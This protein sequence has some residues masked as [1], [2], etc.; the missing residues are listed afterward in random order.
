MGNQDS[1]L[2]STE[3]LGKKLFVAARDADTKTVRKII[4]FGLS[5]RTPYEQ[6]R[7][8]NW[9]YSDGWRPL[10]RAAFGGYKD[11]IKLLLRAGALGHITTVDGWTSSHWAVAQRR[12]GVVKLLV[13]A[14]M[15]LKVRTNGHKTALDLAVH[16]SPSVVIARMILNAGYVLDMNISN[17]IPAK[18]ATYLYNLRPFECTDSDT[19][20]V[21]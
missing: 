14:G 6:E 16:K 17:S 10:H 1:R 7:I 19:I 20:F 15:D 13:N 12:T 21:C 5:L 4:D 2:S 8:L 3:E 18:V 9:D 11:V